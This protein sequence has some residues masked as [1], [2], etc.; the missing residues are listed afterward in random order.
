MVE[1]LQDLGCDKNG[2]AL[3]DIYFFEKM[4]KIHMNSALLH[5]FLVPTFS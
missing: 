1:N 4:K 3:I 5:I 2:P